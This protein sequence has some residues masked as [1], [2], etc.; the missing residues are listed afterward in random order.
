VVAQDEF[1]SKLGRGL[2]RAYGDAAVNGHGATILTEKLN[3][4]ISFDDKS[5][6]VCC[7]AGLTIADLIENFLPRGWFPMVVPGTKYVTIGGAIASD[8]H[9]KN[10]HREGSFVNALRS[11]TLL[12]A[13]GQLVKCSSSE[14]PDLFWATVGG[15][16]LTGMIVEVELKLQKVSTSYITCRSI[17]THNL[18][19]T[20]RCFAELEHEFQYSVAWIDCLAAKEKLGRGIVMFGNH[21]EPDDL[22]QNKA[23]NPLALAGTSALSVPFDLPSFVLNRYSIGTFNQLFWSAHVARDRKRLVPYEPYFFP[24]DRIKSWNR[25]YGKAGFVQYQCVVP[26]SAESAIAKM[27]ELSAQYGMSS[28]LAV[29]KRFGPEVGLLSFPR[30]GITLTLDMPV[31]GQLFELIA[32]LNDLVLNSGGRVYLAKDAYLTAEHFRRMYPNYERWLAI[33]TQVDPQNVFRSALSER[34][35]LSIP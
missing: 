31:R 33:K 27:L 1:P 7:E 18:R 12:K 28:F 14:E 16:G 30:A 24:L 2:G 8:I 10:H 13:N 5:G 35:K 11:F 26:P 29:L 19:E 21:A 15:M 23:R 32:R 3:R 9:G 6:I 17:R 25:L 34:L 20:L 4:L 22:D